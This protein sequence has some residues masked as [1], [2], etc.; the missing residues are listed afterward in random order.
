MVQIADLDEYIYLGGRKIAVRAQHESLGFTFALA[1][2]AV[3]ARNPMTT[4]R[5]AAVS[6]EVHSR[7]SGRRVSDRCRR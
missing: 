1:D 6:Q 7:R 3:A 5:T 2:D 4:G